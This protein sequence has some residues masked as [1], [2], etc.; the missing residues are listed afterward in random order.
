[1]RHG[2]KADVTTTDNSMNF[3]LDSSTVNARTFETH[4]PKIGFPVRGWRA[5][6][7][8]QQYFPETDLIDRSH[9]GDKSRKLLYRDSKPVLQALT[10]PIKIRPKLTNTSFNDSFPQQAESGIN[11]DVAF[12]W[13]FNLLNVYN[14][15]NRVFGQSTNTWSVTPGVFLGLGTTDLS[16]TTTRPV[17][18]FERNA[19]TISTGGFIMFGFNNINIGAAIGFD[20][21]TGQ[22]N[23]LWVYQDK[24]WYGLILGLDLVK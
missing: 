14:G 17:I 23:K 9:S 1:V 2:L 24:R 22:D 4:Y 19:A 5:E 20:H 21:A 6:L 18:E 10:I 16:A 3:S 13:K 12:G 7:Q 11:V 15:K 8:G